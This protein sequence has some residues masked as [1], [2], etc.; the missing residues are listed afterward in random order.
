MLAFPLGSGAILYCSKKQ[1]CISLSMIKSRYIALIY[2]MLFQPLHL[3]AHASGVFSVYYG[4]FAYP[5]VPKYYV[6]QNILTFDITTFEM[7][8]QR[9]YGPQAYSY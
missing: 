9:R 3:M 7:L 8:L 2:S 6:E 4:C 5:K 1:S